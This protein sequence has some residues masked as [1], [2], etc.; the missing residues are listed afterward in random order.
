LH[1]TRSWRFFKDCIIGQALHTVMIV[2]ALKQWISDRPPPRI[3][4]W[5]S[6]FSK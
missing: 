3:F 4:F 5:Q 2:D 6:L 1:A